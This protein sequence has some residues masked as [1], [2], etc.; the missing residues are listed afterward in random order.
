[1]SRYFRFGSL[2]WRLASHPTRRSSTLSA[3]YLFPAGRATSAGVLPSRESMPNLFSNPLIST[4]IRDTQ[5]LCTHIHSSMLTNVRSLLNS[6]IWLLRTKQS[7]YKWCNKSLDIAKGKREER[8]NVDASPDSQCSSIP[9]A[10]PFIPPVEQ[11]NAFIIYEAPT[12][13]T[14]VSTS[15]APST[16]VDSPPPAEVSSEEVISS[17]S[18]DSLPTTGSASF[19]PGSCLADSSE[20]VASSLPFAPAAVH[21]VLGTMQTV[22]SYVCEG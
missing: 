17:V 18:Q 12:T 5:A 7:A 11:T 6:L 22:Y 20:T 19:L 14:V 4:C 9:A 16:I 8:K 2:L 21:S 15:V 3:N 13:P 1:M 10:I